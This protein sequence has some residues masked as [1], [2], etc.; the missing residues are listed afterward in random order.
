MSALNAVVTTVLHKPL[1]K[2]N[3]FRDAPLYISAQHLY[4]PILV[5]NGIGY[6]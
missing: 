1:Y 5:L 3:L 4:Q 2:T 6:Q